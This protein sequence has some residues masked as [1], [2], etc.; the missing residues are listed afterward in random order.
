MPAILW[1]MIAV[2]LASLLLMIVMPIIENKKLMTKIKKLWTAQRPLESFIRPNHNYSY[3]F[4]TYKHQY[5]ANEL[6]DDKTWS[7]L[8][9]DSVFQNMN[10]NFTAIGEMRLFAT[11]RHMFEVNN[12]SLIHHFKSDSLFR[13][14]LSLHLAQIGKSIYPVFPD[15]VAFIKRN[16]FYMI[17]TYLPIAFLISAFITPSVGVPLTII[18]SIFNMILS[19]LL[20]RTFEQDLNSMFYT[21]N[22]IKKAYAIQQFDQTPHL[23]VNFKHFRTARR[24]SGL[25]GRVNTNDETSIF[26]MLFK[27]ILMLDYHLFHLIQNSFKTY[28]DEV[29]ACYDYV[30]SIDNHYAVALWQETL[31]EYTLPEQTQHDTITFENL[32][33]PLITDAVPNSLSINQHILLTGSNASGKSTFMKAVALNIVLSQTIHTA[34]AHNFIY[35]PGLVYTSMVNQDDIL[36]GDSY[37]MSEVKSIKRLFDIQSTKKIYVFIDEIFKGTNTTE[38]IAASESVLTYLNH[39]QSFRVIA[40]THD[41]ELSTLLEDDYSNYHFNE[42][43]SDNEISFDFKIK[44]GKADTRNA[45]ELLRIMRFP[46]IIYRRAKSKASHNN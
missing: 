6:L 22:V 9:L 41:I 30:A 12:Q 27:S 40:A 13:N 38:R 39:L 35:K 46:N 7:D 43:I 4:D 18:A 42:S 16:H 2:I 24:F 10:F 20:K 25:L 23:D 33:H 32:T 3:Q 34:T 8:N 44:S 29:M 28:E 1:F 36:S 11:L 5:N 45:I 21:S 17:C 26:S 19:G 37:F 15:Q 31:D 14:Q